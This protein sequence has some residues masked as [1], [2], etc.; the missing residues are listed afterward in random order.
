MESE[1]AFSIGEVE[2]LVL[3]AYRGAGFSW[4]SAQEAGKAAGWLASRGVAALDVFARLLAEID[5][6]THEAV[7]PDI[8]HSQWPQVWT[9]TEAMLCPVATGILLGDLSATLDSSTTIQMRSVL[10]PVVLV[11][12]VVRARMPFTVSWSATRIFPADFDVNVSK[13]Q[14][15]TLMTG[16]SDVVLHSYPFESQENTAA[17]NGL[18][19]GEGSATTFAV[20]LSHKC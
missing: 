12:F 1:S 20:L 16:K 18:S 2:S 14:Q 11:P 6:L 15:S 19:G 17:N 10:A 9:S 3:K 8:T 13:E 7:S 4:G 5:D